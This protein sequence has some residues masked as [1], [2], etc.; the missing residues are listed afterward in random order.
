MKRRGCKQT[1]FYGPEMI[2]EA[3]EER[4][5]LDAAVDQPTQ[6]HA[7]QT[8]LG[9]QAADSP[10][11][12]AAQTATAP[13]T[14]AAA[15]TAQADAA[16]D[17]PADVFQQ[18]LN[19]VLV[20]NAIDQIE[21]VSH[22]AASNGSMVIVYDAQKDNLSTITAM[23]DSVVRSTGEKI[24]TLAFVDHG[25]DGVVKIGADHITSDNLFKH[26][27]D[28][29]ALAKDLAPTAQIE[30]FGCSI[31]HGAEGQALI[32]QIAAY[33]HAV[34]FA[35]TDATGGNAA[36]WSL[37][38]S[39]LPGVTM[40]PLIATE[41]ISGSDSVLIFPA[42]VYPGLGGPPLDSLATCNQYYSALDTLDPENVQPGTVA[43][44][45]TW[46]FTL[47][48]ATTV[49]IGMQTVH[50]ELI[51]GQAGFIDCWLD[52][53]SGST[54]DPADWLT[55]NDD[56]G[57]PGQRQVPDWCGNDSL[58]WQ[59]NLAA[60]TYSIQA[61]SWSDASNQHM[62]GGYYLLSNIPL[63]Y[64]AGNP[65]VPTSTGVPDPP[66]QNE[67][68]TPPYDYNVSSH[69]SDPQGD[70]L[71]YQ[72]GSIAYQGGLVLDG[73]SL[74]TNTGVFTFTNHADS[75]GSVDIQVKAFDGEI[76][77]QYQTF[78][79]TVLPVND[80]PI[81]SQP[82][83]DLAFTEGHAPTNIVLN[84]H[85]SDV[86]TPGSL[87][88][89]V[90]GNTNPSLFLEPDGVTIAGG[91][92]TLDYDPNAIG[93]TTITIHCADPDG[94]AVDTSFT[95]TITNSDYD[96]PQGQKMT[97]AAPMN[98]TGDANSVTFTLVGYDSDRLTPDPTQQRFVIFGG[99]SMSTGGYLP[100][101]GDIVAEDENGVVTTIQYSATGH[102]F[103]QKF[104]YTPDPNYWGDDTF[105]YAFQTTSG[106]WKGLPTTGSGTAI[107]TQTL[108]TYDIALADLGAD[109][110]LDVV[111]SDGGANQYNYYSL[112]DGTGAFGADQNIDTQV[113]LAAR[114]S[115]SM[116][117]GDFNNDGY[118]DV[119]IRN[120]GTTNQADVVYLWNNTLG[121][122]QTAVQF[123]KTTTDYGVAVADFNGDGN[124]DIV[125]GSGGT[126]T[127]AA[128]IFWGNGDGTFNMTPY[129]LPTGATAT[130][131]TVAAGDFNNDGFQDIFC[132][133]SSYDRSV[134]Y[135]NDGTGDFSIRPI[136]L[137]PTSGRQYVYD[138]A[139]GDVDG[140]GRLDIV[141]ARN[142]YD[143]WMYKN[144]ITESDGTAAWTAVRIT[145]DTLN[146]GS[147]RLADVDSDGD[148]DVITADY[149]NGQEARYYLYNGATFDAG[150]NIGAFGGGTYSRSVAVGDVNGDGDI[151]VVV[152][153]DGQTNRLFNNLGFDLGT[154]DW[155][156]GGPTKVTIHVEAIE[157]WSFEDTTG[158]DG[159][160]LSESYPAPPEGRSYTPENLQEFGTAGIVQDSVGGKTTWTYVTEDGAGYNLT[161]G[162]NQPGGFTVYHPFIDPLQTVHDYVDGNE[163]LQFSIHALSPGITVDGSTTDHAAVLLSGGLR[164]A[165]LSQTITLYDTAD[166]IDANLTGLKIEWDMSI[167]SANAAT[168]FTDTS[169]SQYVTMSVYNAGDPS[170]VAQW[171]T[172]SGETALGGALTHYT[173][174][175]P[176]SLVSDIHNV[177]ATNLVVELHVHGFDWYLDAA[178]DNFK[179]TPIRTTPFGSGLSAV[180]PLTDGVSESPAADLAA[181]STFDV[182]SF[183]A[184]PVT[185]EPLLT[186]IDSF[187]SSQDLSA[188]ST[189][190]SSQDSSLL[191]LLDASASAATTTGLVT[192]AADSGASFTGGQ[193]VDLSGSASVTDLSQ[194]DTSSGGGITG[195]TSVVSAAD[196]GD[197]PADGTA[198]ASEP[199]TIPPDVLVSGGPGTD[200]DVGVGAGAAPAGA[201]NMAF[202]K[203]FDPHT[204]LAFDLDSVD[205]GMVLTAT[206]DAAIGPL[207]GAEVRELVGKIA[208]GES[209]TASLDAVRFTDF[210]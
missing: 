54:P 183:A 132:G 127:Q 33:T 77:S 107:G 152:G 179:L 9:A 196:A 139:V 84:Q 190:T 174:N 68:F 138:S 11:G 35:S 206:A 145:T 53:Y 118:V 88:Y 23:L 87:G 101:H 203:G 192:A 12:A 114:D 171:A 142:G 21:S 140:D 19:V 18:N 75:S 15:Q 47:T 41:T 96:L 10:D 37:E 95:V 136:E 52:L 111:A 92:L 110:T 100:L 188:L 45:E 117:T 120:Y 201:W 121:Q 122:F 108:D 112:N 85:F 165:T 154:T 90:I 63:T 137:L 123:T 20:S 80:P 130:T 26:V 167:W 162:Q 181:S 149:A 144:T 93:T 173:M 103:Y 200:S 170:H 147:I 102:Y 62:T 44:A 39:S 178:I 58:L 125:F 184:V 146:T 148:L 172:N 83:L 3:L 25:S 99:D 129:V 60:G 74:N 195:Q 189:V 98:H 57:N 32:D 155:R 49:S 81:V 65:N 27:A 70:T 176:A 205:A 78:T 156:N 97:I 191:S 51:H 158:Y 76:Y 104:T 208:S 28:L 131:S 128:R 86:E 116:A 89:T 5:V 193:R 22:A 1:R 182:V 135:Y 109:G 43:Y 133:M 4:I 143:N 197:S 50:P 66:A 209:G 29:E 73:L 46:T 126:G 199:T 124:L 61:T 8:S 36:D 150:R 168:P 166:N 30:F 210:L 72:L 207:V 2:L 141:I 42:G 115:R 24:G 187:S 69:F 56:W 151:D 113:G 91:T 175:A 159:W 119:V 82:I 6:D 67:D 134:V 34:V 164:D 40:A 17:T 177:G 194:V 202:G 160:T 157:N 105:Q 106:A 153:L 161:T 13:Q 186:A 180:D 169:G 59:M 79:F 55:A 48:A 7:D 94:A 16:Q 64:S 14:T 198:I 71:T 38:Y 163:Q 204:A 185:T 31:A